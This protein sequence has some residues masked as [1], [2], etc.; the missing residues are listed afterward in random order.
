MSRPRRRLLF[1]FQHAPT[2]GAP[3]M[4]RQHRYLAALAQRGW[5]VDVVSTPVSYL[6]GEIPEPYRGRLYV[7][8]DIDGVTHHWVRAP[9][10]IHGSRRRRALNYV[11]FAATGGT[12]A[13]VL[14]RPD[15]VFA[16]SPPL[17]VAVAGALLARRF[18]RPF[19]LEVRDLWPESAAAVG[20]LSPSS[21]TYR[22]LQRAASWSTRAAAGVVVP[23]PG[24]V[25]GVRRY[26]AGRVELVTGAVRDAGPGDGVRETIRRELGVDRDRR[27]F[28]YV[29]ALGVAN[30]LDMLLDAIEL[31]PDDLPA[32]FVLAGDGSA[33]TA[34]EER[35][36]ARPLRHVSILPAARPARVAELLAASDVG[37]HVLKP[38]A[39]FDAALPNKLLDYLSAHRPFITTTPGLPE[40]LARE[41]GGGF[42]DSAE[43]L[44]A[45]LERW[46]RLPHEELFR[47]GEA[48]FR[49][50]IERFGFEANLDRLELLLTD[51]ATGH[52]WQ[53]G[54]REQSSEPDLLT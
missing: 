12:L 50:G 4:Y 2:R 46:S 6:T 53:Q 24:L 22:V 15:V 54:E 49:Y 10:G 39:L 37:L 34:L 16:S 35:L 23:T 27:L 20:W 36:R 31:L 11:S 45:E 5:V 18:R 40:R 19:V 13:A 43:A 21:R 42:A 41:S 47:R 8:E 33:R 7:R 51:C 52:V 25:E 14:P 26:G 9:A 38:S 3:G 17:P 29:G 48:G 32:G 44:A 30:G 1:V 28:V